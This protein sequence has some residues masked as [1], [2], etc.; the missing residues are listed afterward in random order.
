[1]LAQ[2]PAGAAA[3]RLLLPAGVKPATIHQQAAHPQW[4]EP[5]MCRSPQ[6]IRWRSGWTQDL[7][8]QDLPDQYL[9]ATLLLVPP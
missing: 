8:D 6:L 4:L 1:M 3:Q 5:Q 7:S 2:E 9:F